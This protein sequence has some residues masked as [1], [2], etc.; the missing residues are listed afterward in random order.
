MSGGANW[1]LGTALVL[2]GLAGCGPSVHQ[3][4]MNDAEQRL[5]NIV[6]AYQDAHGKLGHGPKDA[7][8]LKPFLKSYGDPEQLLVSPNDGQ[9]FVVIWNADPTRGGPTMYMGM[10][11]ILAY[12]Q[13]GKGGQRAIVDVRTVPRTIPEAD[14]SQLTFVRGHKPAA[15]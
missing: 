14:F 1:R 2:I 13:N 7:D 4:P 6:S 10:W 3:V 8:E 15:S 9:P 11:Q 5:A 12:E